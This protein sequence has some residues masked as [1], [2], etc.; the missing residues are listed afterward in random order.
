[1]PYIGTKQK[2]YIFWRIDSQR[3][4]HYDYESVLKMK[5]TH[6]EPMP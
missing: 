6:K 3:K 1:M 4:I 5:L 2:I